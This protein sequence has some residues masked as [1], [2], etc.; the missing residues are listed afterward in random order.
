MHNDMIDSIHKLV[1]KVMKG[2]VVT[3]RNVRVKI[4][5]CEVLIWQ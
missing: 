5:Y 4:R 1:K 3:G 2:Y